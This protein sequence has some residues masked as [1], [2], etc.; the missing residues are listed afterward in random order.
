MK[1]I[2]SIMLLLLTLAACT[3]DPET[4][5]EIVLDKDTTTEQTIYA[6]Q[7]STAKGISFHADADWFATVKEVATKATDNTPVD[8][9]TLSQYEGGAGD[10]TLT[11]TVK[12]NHT[13][14]DRK[15]EISIVC[16]TTVIKVTIEQKA[17]NKNGIKIKR[18][19]TVEYVEAFGPQYAKESHN[20]NDNVKFTYSY[21]QEGRIAKVVQS[22]EDEASTYLFD[23]HIVGEITVNESLDN[24]APSL[25]DDYKCEHLLTLN[26]QGNVENIRSTDEYKG[27]IQ[28]V[29]TGD[30]R[31]AELSSDASYESWNEKYFYTDGLLTKLERK[32]SMYDPDIYDFDIAKEYANRYPANKANIDFNAFIINP[33]DDTMAQI[34]Y[35]IGLLGKGSDCLI[36]TVPCEDYPV[37]V[38]DPG[39]SYPEPD[40]V[41]KKT[42]TEIKWPE[43]ATFFPVSY[44]LDDDKYVT[45]F[46]YIEPYEVIE[47]YYE[48]HVGHELVHPGYPEM[49][50]KYQIKNEKS[51]KLRDEKN[52]YTYTV[53]YE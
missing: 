26:K 11:L 52:T 4:K 40:K 53:T 46:W 44:E 2:T 28:A 1:R 27:N 9:I 33:L 48:I 10:F 18:V 34:S 17:T 13:Q 23:Y 41:I 51:T 47:Y 19:K 7:T 39:T 43:N 6:D 22:Y 25:P 20:S 14:A 42:R 3:K 49:G 32:V 12:E 30:N 36:E 21:D 38:V 24:F 37:S 5:N 8:W 45:K 50:Y 31:L 15:A 16:G 29:Y 35:Q